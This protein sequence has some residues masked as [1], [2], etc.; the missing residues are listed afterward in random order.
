MM[1]DNEDLELVKKQT[2]NNG[3]F[4]RE[5]DFFFSD[6]WKALYICK[7]FHPFLTDDLFVSISLCARL[8]PIVP[9]IRNAN[10]PVRLATSREFLSRPEVSPAFEQHCSTMGQVLIYGNYKCLEEGAPHG[11]RIHRR[12]RQ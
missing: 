7:L 10:K 11:K 6:Q 2:K 4:L 9:V 5:K 3:V 12:L 1:P 8:L